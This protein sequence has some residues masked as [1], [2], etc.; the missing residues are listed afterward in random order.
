MRFEDLNWMDVESY[1]KQDSRAILVIGA[2]EQ[3]GYLSLLADVRIPMALADAAS[4]RTGVPVAPP[5]NYGIS[6]SF[7]GYPGT[8]SLG[9]HTF[10]HVVEEVVRDLHR[11]GFTRILILNGHGGNQ[12]AR[13]ILKELVNEIPDLRLA[14]ISWWESPAVA[15]IAAEH[16]LTGSHAAWVEA[17][18][19]TRVAP[20]PEGVK[21]VEISGE[22]Q[23]TAA[24]RRHYGDGQMGGAYQAGPEI[25]DQV[26]EAVAAEIVAELDHL[27]SRP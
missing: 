14:W 7:A 24:N 21:Q 17:F 1:L 23:D 18:P 13:S 26:F 15:A 22:I 10:L 9:T 20:L 16:G 6:T 2:C 11:Q 4:E 25:M 8:V 12:P 19:F 3:H 27:K 5:V